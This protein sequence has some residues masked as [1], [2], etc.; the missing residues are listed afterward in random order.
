MDIRISPCRKLQGRIEVPGDKS[1][2]HRAV[3]LGALSEGIT[4]ISGFLM[5]ADCLSTISCFEK[6]GVR[7]DRNDAEKTVT[8]EGRSLHGLRAPSEL[9]YTGNSGTTT[10]IISGILAG[11]SFESTLDG[12]SSIRRRPMKR[13]IDPL[14]AMGASVR[15]EKE[16][17][18]VPLRIKGGSLHGICWRSPVASAQVKSGIL[19]A[20]LYADSETSVLEPALSRN[21]TELM[22][23]AFGGNVSS[24][25]LPDPL[26]E[27]EKRTDRISS[28]LSSDTAG[29]WKITVRPEPHLTGRK[30]CVPG[31]ISSAA[32]FMA[33]AAIVPGSEVLISNVGVNPTRN[34]IL[35]V[36]RAM[37]ADISL[38]DE[39]LQGFEETASILVRSS[40]LHGTVIGGSLIPTLIDELPVCAVLACFAEGETVIRDARELRVKE[41]DRIAVM[42]EELNKMGADITP[43]EDGMIIRGGRS[44]HG[45]EVDAHADHRAAMS[46]TVAALA[47]EGATTIRGAECVGISYPD[48]F[49]DLD[50]LR[51]GC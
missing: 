17:G 47:A 44:L 30:I 14:L 32:Y 4:E 41:S 9:L 33:A 46:L 13:I 8:V 3:M 29:G 2:S 51:T 24:E 43:T 1:V 38:S 20:G 48:F 22:L 11:Q 37:G 12:D 16:N 26:P 40:S 34:G 42:T 7:V 31:D 28:G 5:S 27:G 35:K 6:M 45:A 39:K 19:L 50:R 10:R 25:P 36:M 21:H 23:K 49:K 15:S 18:C